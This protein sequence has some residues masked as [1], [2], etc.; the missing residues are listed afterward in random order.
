[1]THNYKDSFYVIDRGSSFVFRQKRSTRL[2]EPEEIIDGFV[3]F[4]LEHGYAPCEQD[5][6]DF[7]GK[8]LKPI[9]RCM[10]ELREREVLIKTKGFRKNPRGYRFASIYDIPEK[11]H[12][13]PNI[14]ELVA[15]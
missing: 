2:A 12:N 1:M 8:T 15:K 11:Y 10:L 13:E 4:F 6:V 14:H 7:L 3:R 9:R 5:L